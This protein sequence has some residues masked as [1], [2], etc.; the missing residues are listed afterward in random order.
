MLITSGIMVLE[1]PCLSVRRADRRPGA[2]LLAGGQDGRVGGR[3]GFQ[4]E[5]RSSGLVGERVDRW[6]G[7]R[8]AGERMDGY[9]I[10]HSL[11]HCI[12]FHVRQAG[13]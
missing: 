5:G 13:G 7:G 11:A 9:H 12:K 8:R 1:I 2:G 3:T 10:A 6:S 4:G